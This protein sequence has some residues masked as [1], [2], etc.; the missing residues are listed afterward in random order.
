MYNELFN[1]LDNYWKQNKFNDFDIQFEI[2]D[3]IYS[4]TWGTTPM[5]SF[6]EIIKSTFKPKRFVVFGSSIGFQCFYFRSIFVDIPILGYDIHPGRIEFANNLKKKY[7]IENCEF[8]LSDFVE[9]E[10]QDGDLIWQ[11]NLCVEDD[12]LDRMNF[13]ILSTYNDIQLVSYRPVLGNLTMDKSIFF[14]DI[15]GRVAKSFTIKHFQ[16]PTSWSENQNFYLIQ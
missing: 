16:L 5:S 4:M 2:T 10:I 7:S 13:F 8:I 15:L 3:D 12:L 14:N 6:N 9:S 1:E 11:N